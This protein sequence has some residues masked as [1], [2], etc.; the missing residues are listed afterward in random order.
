[1]PSDDEAQATK[2]EAFAQELQPEI[3]Q[4]VQR[5]VPLDIITEEAPHAV[6]LVKEENGD[7]AME[8]HH[9][10]TEA[11]D[12]EGRSSMLNT[13]HHRIGKHCMHRV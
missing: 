11:V 10:L 8:V 6:T 13:I 12:A 5:D 9:L 2:R 3:A 4:E 1:M 7:T